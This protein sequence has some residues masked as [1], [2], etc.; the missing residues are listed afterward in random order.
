M[1][2]FYELT[3][4]PQSALP[5]RRESVRQQLLSAGLRTPLDNPATGLLADDFALFEII[6]NP[7]M[8]AG[9]WVLVRIPLGRTFLELTTELLNLERLALILQAD[10]IDGDEIMV[11]SGHAGL[12]ALFAFHAR[13]ERAA[14]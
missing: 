3:L 7:A 2:R 6:A 9:V 10:V 12:A 5:L 4:R 13:Y 11:H 1:T 8:P 14:L